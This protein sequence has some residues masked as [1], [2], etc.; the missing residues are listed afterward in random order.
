MN[1]Y[2]LKQKLNLAD[3]SSYYPNSELAKSIN[4]LK[5]YF[6]YGLIFFEND[7]K[8]C[9][10]PD[11]NADFRP[12]RAPNWSNSL[13]KTLCFLTNTKNKFLF[14]KDQG[15]KLEQIWKLFVFC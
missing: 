11:V 6:P 13:R 8:S 9:P 12:L 3:T 5:S 4:T 15:K 14:C 2:T 10:V 7:K 1:I